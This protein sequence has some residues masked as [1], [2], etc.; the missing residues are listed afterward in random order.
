VAWWRAFRSEDIDV[1]MA[2]IHRGIGMGGDK[3]MASL[4]GEQRPS[5]SEKHGKEFLQFRAEMWPL[6]GAADLLTAVKEMG[7][8]VVIGTS[9]KAE[10][11]PAMLE[12]IGAPEMIDDV[13]HSGDVEQSKPAPDIFSTAIARG[14][15][16]PERTIA[17]GDTGWDIEAA[18]RAGCGCIALLTGGWSEAELAEAGALAVYET[19]ADLLSRLAQSPLASLLR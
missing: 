7:L 10:N 15:L 12:A 2:A 5:L 13:V 4:I 11:V 19:P 1:P 9:A 3:M 17:V 6:P 16:D 8:A 14:R 18:R